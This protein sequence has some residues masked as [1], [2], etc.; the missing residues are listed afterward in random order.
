M[1]GFGIVAMTVLVSLPALGA[2]PFHPPQSPAERALDAMLH[3]ADADEGQLAN[4]LG[5]PD[6][7]HRFDYRTILTAR[8]IGVLREQEHDMVENDCGGHYREG[9]VCGF[10]YSPVTCA[11]DQLEHYLYRTVEVKADR[12]MIDYAWPPESKTVAQYTLVKNQT[13]WKIDMIECL[14]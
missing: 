1:R 5:R 6:A 2:A 8:E 3:R 7:D 10:D 12:T 14:P 4:L 13:G 9:E 11:Q